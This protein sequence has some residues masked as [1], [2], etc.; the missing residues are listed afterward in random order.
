[1]SYSGFGYTDIWTTDGGMQPLY[2]RKQQPAPVTRYTHQQAHEMFGSRRQIRR[3]IAQR[4][5]PATALKAQH[6]QVLVSSHAAHIAHRAAMAHRARLHQP[7]RKVSWNKAACVNRLGYHG[8]ATEQM[9]LAAEAAPMPNYE[10]SAGIPLKALI[11]QRNKL[12]SEMW[13][14]R[15][16]VGK[17]KQALSQYP[18][19]HPM[20]SQIRA[21]IKQVRPALRALRAKIKSLTAQIR[22]LKAEHAPTKP[23]FS[24]YGYGYAGEGVEPEHRSLIPGVSGLAIGMVVAVGAILYL[25]FGDKLMKAS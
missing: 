15:Q 10:L 4:L 17:G 19:G 1:M 12:R 9:A 23:E 25:S 14:L 21:Q 2:L 7:I 8:A 18:K 13:G 3:A 22:A 11:A 20:R 5:P 24:G 16:K 6:R